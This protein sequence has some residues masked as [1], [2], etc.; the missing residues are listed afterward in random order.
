M[1]VPGHEDVD[2]RLRAARCG[3][4]DLDAAVDL[5][6]ARQAAFVD[7]LAR[8]AHLVEHLGDERLT[9][10]T[11]LARSS[12]S[13]RSISPRYGSTASNGVVRLERQAGAHAE[14]ADLVEQRRGDRRARC[15]RCI[16]RRRR[17]RSSRSS[18]SRVVDHQVAV[19][20]EVGVRAQRLHD[21]RADREVRHVV[22][23]HAV[24]VQEIGGRRDPRDVVGEVR[25]VGGE[26]RGR[27]L[28]RHRSY[29]PRSR[30]S[31][32]TNMPSV[33]GVGRA[34]AARR[35]RAVATVAPGGVS[36]DE[37]RQRDRAANSSMA[38]GLRG[39]D[40][41]HRV[42][43]AAARPHGCG[44]GEEQLALERRRARVTSL[45]LDPPARVGTPPQHA[46]AAARR[47]EQHAVEGCRARRTGAGRRRRPAAIE[48]QPEPAQRRGPA[49]GLVPGSRRRRPRG[50]RRRM[51]SAIAPALPPG[52][53]A[54][55]STRSPGCGSST[56]TTA[57]LAWSCGV[58]RPSRTAASAPMSPAAAQ[59]ERVGHERAPFDARARRR[60]TPARP[61]RPSRADGFT[62]KVTRRA[63]S[64]RRASRSRRRRRTCR[65]AAR[66]IQSG[67]DVRTPMSATSSAGGH[68]HGG[69]AR[70]SARQHTVD[71]AARRAS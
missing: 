36:A 34:A 29:R 17:R 50:R 55:S 51:R 65:R 16:R 3:V 33:R 12:P 5:D 62:R 71:E 61:R 30:S 69:P 24:D 54:T 25:E 57:W 14:R 20:E 63:S 10:E 47:V 37:L 23:V 53:A 56:A 46:E 1:P 28:H 15:A 66:T 2:A 70:A 27:D 67:C 32:R 49:R 13:S 7:E 4:V 52:A 6:L 43:E 39:R 59:H 58:A 9:A 11:G 18:T 64:V 45:G 8:G 19:E 31:T 42:D 22:P 40:R 21:R 44:R 68:D 26:D 35:A 41:A 60:A 48:S 38:Q